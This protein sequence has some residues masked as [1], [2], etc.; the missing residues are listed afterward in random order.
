MDTVY[1]EL[2][3]PSQEITD[4]FRELLAEYSPSCVV[5]DAQ[6][7]AGA[8][9]GFQVVRNDQKIAGPAFTINLSI[10]DWVNTLPILSRAQPGDVIVMACHGLATTAMWGGLTATVSHKFGIAG[11]I[12]DGAAR[13]IDEI[14]DI[15]F[16]VWYRT[17]SPRQSPGA[18]HDRIEPVQVNVPVSVGGQ[19]IFPG[20]IVVADENGV[21][22][23]PS[24]SAKEV[25][26]SARGVAARE[27]EIRDRISS[28][29]TAAD[30]R[31][32]FG[33]L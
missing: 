15:G 10:D 7:R 14:R 30:L 9:G 16:P 32:E 22:T 11:A 20:D 17:T 12:I 21:A 19:V 13:D 23:V 31:A 1:N 25:L 8:M 4:G 27:N 3:R 24:G 18:V 33:N 28:G 2:V 29:A 6:R 5:T 26:E